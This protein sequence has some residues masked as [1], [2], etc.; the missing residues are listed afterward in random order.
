MSW[1]SLS[2]PFGSLLTAAKMTQVASN[3]ASAMYQESGA[4]LPAG[5]WSFGGG[6][7]VASVFHV[8][9]SAHIG[10]LNVDSGLSIGGLAAKE[11]IQSVEGLPSG[12]LVSSTNVFSTYA[13]ASITPKFAD[14]LILV[15]AE[16]DIF[17]PTQTAVGFGYAGANLCRSPNGTP[18]V[19]RPTSSAALANV[20][21]IGVTNSGTQ[22][23]RG[24]QT[25]RYQE[26]SPGSGTPVQYGLRFAAG[27]NA[28]QGVQA[29]Y[30][31]VR[32]QEWR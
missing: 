8:P 21:Y 19:L 4:P 14:S 6:V 28:S 25:F 32:V 30:G 13:V 9:G 16:I 12:T 24:M 15:D 7:D 26:A 11:L 10:A 18:V 29:Q 23:L 20:P 1:S 2:F 31:M 17:I 3:F 22:N 27:A 5:V